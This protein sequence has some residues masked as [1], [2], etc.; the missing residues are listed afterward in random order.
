M[1]YVLILVLVTV[2]IFSVYFSGSD[3]RTILILCA[4]DKSSQTSDIEGAKKYSLD[5]KQRYKG[6]NDGTL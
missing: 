5:A 1:N 2:S 3:S 4:G 6:Y